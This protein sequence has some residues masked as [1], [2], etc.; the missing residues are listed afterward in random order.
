MSS[1]QL[2]RLAVVLAAAV[3]VWAVLALTRRSTGDRA[4]RLA[5]PR[6]DTSAVDTVVFAKGA[7]TALLVRGADH[8][9]R[10]DGYPAAASNVAQLLSALADTASNSTEL[11]AESK[12]AQP[13]LGVAA[14]S[15]QHVRVIAGGHVALDW[16]TG[17]QTSDYAGLYVRPVGGDTV[18]SLHGR[19]TGAFGHGLVE[20]RDHTIVAL[21]PDSVHRVEVQRGRERYAL[22]R[23]AKGSWML[24]GA[25][26]ADT[27]AAKVLLD[28][29]NPLSAE[30][31][32]TPA[33]AKAAQFARPTA[34]VRVF[35]AASAPLAD[36][37]FDS[38][39]TGV[40]ARSD[41][42]AT[43]FQVESWTMDGVAPAEKT[44]QKNAAKPR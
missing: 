15:G 5:I 1:K 29:L 10:D 16:I 11:V 27:T 36:V 38:T 13:G 22:V 21:A 3:V 19:L 7:D 20:W 43:V 28:H 31:F 34:R 23:G 41:T 9:W 14:D 6:V 42:G 8:R 24:A 40:W 2:V 44:L 4:I 39:K 26:A 30:S 37:L 25:G 33:Q 17:H 12:A 18:Y 35:G 32:A